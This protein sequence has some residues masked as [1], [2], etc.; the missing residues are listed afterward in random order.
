MGRDER[1]FCECCIMLENNSL[2][3]KVF[4]LELYIYMHQY[5][6]QM[7][8]IWCVVLFNIHCFPDGLVIFRFAFFLK[9]LPRTG[10]MSFI[11]N[12]M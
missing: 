12:L 9:Y 5:Q 3:G 1:I 8:L 10:V 7:K 6:L 4:S 11:L 2:F